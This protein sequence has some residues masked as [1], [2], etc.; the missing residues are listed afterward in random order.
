MEELG[1]NPAKVPP[2]GADHPLIKKTFDVL[3]RRAGT[4]C[5]LSVSKGV[6]GDPA[7]YAGFARIE[8]WPA[9][10]QSVYST[11]YLWVQNTGRRLANAKTRKV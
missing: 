4:L 7:K 6:C 10:R 5:G 3:G 2:E 8:G 1:A 9:E 11:Y